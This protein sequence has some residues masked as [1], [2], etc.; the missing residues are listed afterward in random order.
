M[1]E[2]AKIAA[3][4]N[5]CLSNDLVDVSEKAVQAG[6]IKLLAGGDE[7]ATANFRFSVE[8]EED[9][10]LFYEVRISSDTYKYSKDDSGVFDMQRSFFGNQASRL[11]ESLPDELR[12]KLEEEFDDIFV[13]IYVNDVMV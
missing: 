9:S 4:I 7:A 1:S 6:R 11:V 2:A 3:E 13:S 5:D 12:E 8:D 10:E